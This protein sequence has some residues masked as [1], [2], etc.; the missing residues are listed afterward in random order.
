MAQTAKSGTTRAEV[1]FIRMRADILSGA[2]RPGEKL[3]F[4]WLCERYSVSIGVAREALSRLVELGFVVA[5]PQLGYRVVSLS[6]DDLEDLTTTRCEIEGAALALSVE[7]GDL[8]WEAAV[9]ASHHT[10]D[11]TPP[12]LNEDPGHIN[13]EWTALHRTFHNA[14][15]SGC[16]APR[17]VTIA[18]SLRDAT[19]I[20]RAWAHDVGEPDRRDFT[21]EHRALTQAALDRDHRCAADMLRRHLRNT[22]EILI[23]RVAAQ[24]VPSSA[25]PS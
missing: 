22:A 19:E 23:Q 11:R 25:T 1:A 6:L 7:H 10:L 20:Y 3:P 16:P 21:A 24:L 4:A 12:W 14:L 18:G 15:L 2:V 17:L 5:E 8:A 9:L 13:A